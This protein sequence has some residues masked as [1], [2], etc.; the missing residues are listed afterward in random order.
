MASRYALLHSPLLERPAHRPLRQ[1]AMGAF[2]ITRPLVASGAV[3][4]ASRALAEAARY[5]Q[6]RKTFGLPIFQHGQ[7]A[8]M[9]AEQAIAVESSRAMVWRSAG[10]KDAGDPRTTYYASIAKALASEQAVA[11]ANLAVQSTSSRARMFPA[12]ADV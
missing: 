2:D 1:I 12:S 4:L 3:G 5:S 10:A 6:E 9:L 8:Q 7:V 11:C